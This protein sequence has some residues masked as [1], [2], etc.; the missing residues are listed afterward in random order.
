M[1]WMCKL[2][3]MVYDINF[4]ESGHLFNSEESESG[5]ENRLLGSMNMNVQFVGP[6]SQ[7]F[8]CLNINIQLQTG[9]SVIP[10]YLSLYLIYHDIKYKAQLLWS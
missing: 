1:L 9:Y 3:E 8:G 6:D 5:F 10:I 7:I 4:G 2:I